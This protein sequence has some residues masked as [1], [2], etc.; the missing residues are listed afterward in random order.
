MFAIEELEVIHIL[1]LSVYSVIIANIIIDTIITIVNYLVLP[2][3]TTEVIHFI[4]ISD[5]E[6][7]ERICY[8]Y[9][10]FACEEYTKN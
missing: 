8:T 4:S 3:L 7:N 6:R 5:E 2:C 1:K 10:K 9:F